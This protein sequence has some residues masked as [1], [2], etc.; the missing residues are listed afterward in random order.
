MREV[1]PRSGVRRLSARAAAAGGGI[2]SAFSCR[3]PFLNRLP[4]D[5]E[6]RCAL[7]RSGLRGFDAAYCFGAYE[8]ALRELIHLYK[9]GRMKP[10]AV[11]LA[12][13]WR[14]HCRATS[15]SM[16]WSPCRCTGGAAGS[17]ASINRNCWRGRSRGAA[18]I[19][20]L[21]RGAARVAPPQTQAGSEQ[22]RAGARTSPAPFDASAAVSA[23]LRILLVDDVMTTGATAS[24]CA[25]A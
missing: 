11:R 13:C 7:C 1:Y 18:G 2:L 23:G 20:V 9:Y 22:Y 8:G 10:L 6:G 19:P 5:A 17:A 15:G 16:P 21:Q 24:A 25:R 3:T 14:R 12:T 4:L